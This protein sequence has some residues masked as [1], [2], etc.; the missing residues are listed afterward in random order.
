ML[1]LF[2]QHYFWFISTMQQ[3]AN[4]KWRTLAAPNKFGIVFPSMS[5]V[6]HCYANRSHARVTP[7]V[8]GASLQ[9]IA[10]LFGV[11]SGTEITSHSF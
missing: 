2:L 7:M 10:I 6:Y 4:M 5:L 11:A 1:S 8:N 3:T 9:P